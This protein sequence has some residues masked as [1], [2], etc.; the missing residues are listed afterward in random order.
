MKLLTRYILSELLKVFGITLTAM[1]AIMIIVGVAVE[2]GQQGLGP[3][4]ILQLI[5]YVLP[6][7]LLFAVPGTILFTVCSVYG[8]LSSANEVVAVKSLGISPA[9]IVVPAYVLAFILSVITVWLN[10]VAVSWGREGMH[11]VVIQSVEEITYGMLRTHKSYSTNRFSITVKA[12]DGRMLIRPV[13]IVYGTAGEAPITITAQEAYLRSDLEKNMLTVVLRDGRMEFHGKATLAF[14]D[15]IE[16]EIPLSD[17]AK[18]GKQRGKPSNYPL[19]NISTEIATQREKI[20]QLERASA[21]EAAFQMVSGDLDEL[22]STSWNGVEHQIVMARERESRLRTEPYRRLANG[23]SC[24]CF[25]MVGAPLAIWRRYADVWTAFGLC[26]MPILIVYY[27]LLLMGV[28]R[29]KC[30]AW[31]PYSVWLGNMILALTGIW[32]LRKVWRY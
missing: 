14:K 23:F 29:A 32:L 3:V 10:D 7:A 16:H 17:A 8:R 5:P 9:A 4:A 15:T 20:D 25:V 2:A 1:T 6:N 11:R 13:L 24:L 26:F 31:P 27:P 18:K 21:A 22:T 12:V 28:S 30:G 19:R